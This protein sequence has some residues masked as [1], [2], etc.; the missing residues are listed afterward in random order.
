M[1]GKFVTPGVTNAIGAHGTIPDMQK[2]RFKKTY[3]KEWRQHR[4]LSL[5]QLAA[6]MEIE[7]GTELISFASLGRIEKGQQPYSQPVLEALAIALNCEP[8]D[9]LHNDPGKTGELVE[10]VRDLTDE[11]RRQAVAI[12]RALKQAS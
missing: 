11:Q 10:M 12:I 6:R 4:R 8:W 7:P 1:Q 9:L 5:R 3:I 2:R